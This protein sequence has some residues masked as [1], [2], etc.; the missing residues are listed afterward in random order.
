MVGNRRLRG[1]ERLFAGVD[2]TDAGQAEVE[3]LD[4]AVVRQHDVARLEIAMRDLFL[5]RRRERIGQ[6]Y[7]DLQEFLNQHPAGHHEVAQRAS[8]HQLHGQ[9]ANAVGFLGRMDRDDVR[10]VESGDGASFAIEAFETSGFVDEVSR[11][12]LQRDV[13]AEP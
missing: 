3:D 6:R 13:A 8:I 2:A 10:V 9:E 4:A 12:D 11:Q 1:Y 5:M 7:R